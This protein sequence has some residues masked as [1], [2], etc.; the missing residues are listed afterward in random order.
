MASPLC[1]L[2]SRQKSKA[3]A[4]ACWCGRPDIPVSDR[5]TVSLRTCG[6]SLR[7]GIQKLALIPSS[8]ADIQS[9]RPQL[10]SAKAASDTNSIIDAGAGHHPTFDRRARG[11]LSGGCFW[12]GGL[13]A[14]A[15]L[16]WRAVSAATSFSWRSCAD[17]CG[18]LSAAPQP[19]A[20]AGR[21]A[22]PGRT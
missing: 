8:V 2:C 16:L 14:C 21:A 18:Q 5:Q 11:E 6:R 10:E 17:H 12:S 19:T 22:V 4:P 13:H 15:R 1:Y 20:S 3:V 9:M 7:K